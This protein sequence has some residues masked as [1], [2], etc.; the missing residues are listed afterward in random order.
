MV[1]VLADQHKVRFY[2]SPDL[3]HWTY[4]SDFGPAGAVDGWWEC[5]DLFPLAVE[6]GPETRKWILKVDVLKGTGAQ[7]FI[8]EFDGMRFISD[9]ADV[10]ILRVDYGNDFYAA[11]SWSDEPNN[12]RIWIGWL[13]NWHYANV[14]P[15]SPWRGL[16]SI[17]RE[18]HLRKYREAL[19]LVQQPIEEL[20]QLR[21][22]IY[23]A[24][25]I[26]IATI[27]TQIA[28]LKIGIAQ[29]I[30]AEFTLGTAREFGIKICTGETEETLIGYDTQTQELFVDRQRSGE[31]AF[32]EVFARVH[33][34]TLPPEGGKI[35]LHMFLDSCSVEVFG[36]DGY[37]VISDL[38]FP[39]S[40]STRL[41]FYAHDGDVR[42]DRLDIWKLT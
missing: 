32:S 30:Q 40:E 2:A 41:E 25:H 9:T 26:D 5:P 19:R 37:I 23:H 39:L 3:K 11:Q 31:S 14:I 15:T 7:Y 42:L 34:G 27:N 20:K 35:R 21:Q 16:F 22:S 28:P 13:N 38:I 17:P 29:E 12:R 33:R 6:D 36:N 8:G 4:L 24:T 10:H 18:L 1:T